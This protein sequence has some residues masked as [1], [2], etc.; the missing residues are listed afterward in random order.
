MDVIKA[1]LFKHVLPLLLLCALVALIVAMVELLLLLCSAC[2]AD[3]IRRVR[4]GGGPLRDKER[5]IN[6][7]SGTTDD[8]DDD[9]DDLQDDDEEDVVSEREISGYLEESESSSNLINF[10]I[11]RSNKQFMVKLVFIGIKK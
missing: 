10:A 9:D 3:H 2:F 6:L 5:I 7:A 1:V 8:L 11:K 4:L